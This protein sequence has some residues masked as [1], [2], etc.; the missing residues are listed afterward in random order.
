MPPNPTVAML[1]VLAGAWNPRQRTCRGRMIQL[2]PAVAVVVENLR[3]EMSL[4]ELSSQKPEFY[5]AT[6]N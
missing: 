1:T 2:A 5:A 3:L 6:R 4:M